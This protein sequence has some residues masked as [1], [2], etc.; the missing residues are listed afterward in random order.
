LAYP[1]PPSSKRAVKLAGKAI[2]KQSATTKD[3]EL[4]DQWRASHGYVINTF[5]VW[6]KYHLKKSGVEA[7]FAQRLKRRKT[8]EE[9]L[10]R[11]TPEGVPLISDITTMQD[12]AGCRLI[13]DS[14]ED[15]QTFR[16]H[17]HNPKVL[18]NVNHK[19]KHSLEKYNYIES[20]KNTGYRGIHDIFM[21]FP[22][23]H[24]RGD[25]KSKPW[26]GLLVEIQY[27]T[28]VQHA[29]ATA[30]EISDLIDQKHTKFEFG[31]DA[32]GE[33]FAVASELIARK[34][35]NIV[36]AFNQVSYSELTTLLEALEQ[37]LGI[38]ERLKALRKASPDLKLKK[39]NVLNIYM[40]VDG[41][42]LLEAHTYSNAFDAIAMANKLESDLFS[43]NAVYVRAD[44]PSQLRSA[45]RNYFNDPVDFVNLL[46]N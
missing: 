3:I 20:P 19:P 15:I 29:W 39:H 21:H 36:R 13:F 25:E 12:F 9:K 34:H 38:L 10:Q 33:F 2:A 43:V 40:G 11:V 18:R 7:E 17:L 42:Q 4:V 28:R 8:V 5:Q 26:H 22:R 35:E 37:E 31:E 45:Y 6:L 23:G 24:V 41:E 1:K 16:N 32:R 30:L 14:I 46:L 44:N 27:R